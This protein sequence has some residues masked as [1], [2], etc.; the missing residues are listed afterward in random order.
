MKKH[1]LPVL[2]AVSITFSSCNKDN[3]NPLPQNMDYRQ[4]MRNFVQKISSRAKEM[5]SRFAVISQNGAELVSTNGQHDGTPATEY[6]N[7]IDGMGQEDLFYGYNNDDEPTPAD[8]HQWIIGF[9]NMAKSSGKTVLVT[10]YCSTRAKMDDSYLKNNQSGFI[11]FAAD[12]RELDH[13][14]DYPSP[15]FNEN[16]DTVSNLGEA[17]NFLYL[18]NPDN[19]FGSKQAFVD[20]VRATN[21]DVVIMDLFF[22]GEEYSAAQM[23]QLRQKANG[24]K[25][26]LICYMS[27]GEAEDYRYY[28]QPGWKPG[29]PSFIEKEDPYWPGNYYVRYWDPGWQEIICG[30][31]DSYLQKIVAAGFDGVYLDIIDAFEQYEQ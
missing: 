10:D 30:E 15:V 26:L 20:A 1:I 3:G 24:G 31:K 11:S 19:E 5:N 7:A 2:A 9:L 18:I 6:L 17:K 4:E 25:R 28:W 12:R 23:E 22:G 29:N 13:I 16:S 14:P 27:I 21:Y 8:A